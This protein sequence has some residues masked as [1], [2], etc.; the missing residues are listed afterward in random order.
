MDPANAVWYLGANLYVVNGA[1]LQLYGPALGGNVAELR[2]KSDSTTDPN[3]FVELRSDWG[4]LDIRNTK[5]TSWDSTVNGPNTITNYGRAFIHARSTLDP[6]GVT[7]HESRMDVLN[8]EICYLGTHDAEAYGLTWKLVDTT[9]IYIPPGSTNTL[10]DLVQVHGNLLN[11]HIHHNF[12]GMYSYGLVGAHIAT[13]EVDHNIA[14]GLDPHNGSDNLV[15]ENNNS[16]DNGW[17]GIIASR[18]C[19]N[20]IMRNNVSWHNGLDTSNPH[21]NGLMLHRYCN[22]WVVENNLVYDNPDSGIAIFGCYSNIIRNNICLTNQSAGIRLSVGAAYNW[23]EANE[24]GYLPRYGF[25]VFEGDDDPDEETGDT[26]LVLTGR[27]YLNTFTNNYVH[28]YTNDAIKLA[29]G[30]TNTFTGN[31]FEGFNTTFSFEEGTN[32]MVINNFVP[33]D[34]FVELSGS[35]TN[36]C[37]TTFEQQPVLSLQVDTNSTAS[38]ADNSGAIF[39]FGANAVATTVNA[40]GSSASVTW[41]KVGTGANTVVTRNFLVATTSSNVKVTPT[42]W[43]MGGDYSKQWTAAAGST[44]VTVNYIV[45]DLQPGASY[46]VTQGATPLATLVASPQGYIA[47]S[48]SPGTTSVLTYSVTP[49]P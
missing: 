35:A 11:S 43:N 37:S 25:Y 2:L 9:A 17:H 42:I 8:S 49:Q 7:A 16:H 27:C 29:D 23:I 28:D 22:G 36:S 48:A 34:T 6:D 12:F 10:Y 47:F 40:T 31:Q 21:G 24:F 45:G 44:S 38:F 19:V 13:N 3:N 41:R 39:D 14:Y 26:N 30:D 5:I 20:G 4:Y 46:L 15:I 18:F 32:N 33:L 1:Q